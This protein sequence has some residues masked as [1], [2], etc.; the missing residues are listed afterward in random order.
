M[1]IAVCPPYTS[2]VRWIPRS[3]SSGQ[4]ATLSPIDRQ[5]RQCHRG[6][7]STSPGVRKDGASLLI[8]LHFLATRSV[9]ACGGRSSVD[10]RQD[11][12]ADALGND[13]RVQVSEGVD[14]LHPI[15]SPMNHS[16]H[17]GFR[18]PSMAFLPCDCSPD[19]RV[20]VSVGKRTVA[21]RERSP[22][23]P[24]WFGPAWLASDARRVG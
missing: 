24:R 1:P 21:V 15:G 9:G 4:K 5:F 3:H 6:S 18:L 19:R 14:A 8:M 7:A 10:R 2:P 22:R 20:D 12:E 23:L 13:R 16:H 11:G 17:V